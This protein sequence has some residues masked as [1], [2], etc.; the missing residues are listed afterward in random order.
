MN[1]AIVIGCSAYE[2][3]S[4]SQLRFAHRD[5]KRIAMTLL[6]TCG[7]SEETLLILCDDA[8]ESRRPTRTNV[9]RAITDRDRLNAVDGVLF[10]FFSG[11]GF[12]AADE[13]QY[14]L[15]IDCVR[16]ALTDTSLRFDSMLR[17]LGEARADHSV[18]LLDA[19]RN[20]VQ[21]GKSGP[22]APAPVDV[23]A[24]CPPGMVS[25]CSCQP[26]RV[27][28]E[29]ESVQAGV[30]T[31][32]ICEALSDKGRCRTIY[33]LD[34]YLSARVP[35]VARAAGK[36]VQ[37]PYSRVEP[38][39][40]QRLE[41][42]SAQ[43]SNQWRA[44]APIGAERRPRRIQRAIVDAE[45]DPIVAVDLGT[46]YSAV[47]LSNSEGT[48]VIPGADGRLL[49]PSVVH[50]LP[51]LDYL[52]GSAAVEADQYRPEGTV[53]EVKR[54]LGTD[55]NF[56]VADRSIA[57]ELI[58]SLIIRSLR[59][60]AEEALGRPVHRC[61]AS[62]PANFSVAQRNALER[63]F[64]LADFDIMRMIAEPN[65]AAMTL[66]QARP[67]W[68]GP[69]LV[70]DLGGGTF[71]V[72][73]LGYDNS[74][75]SFVCDV[76]AVAGSN[77]VGGTDFDA[78]LMDYAAAE[79]REQ[80]GHDVL[81]DPHLVW[82]LR[83]EAQRAKRELGTQ[84]ATTILVQDVE[85][86]PLG[87]KDISI[88][89]DRDLFRHLTT[90][91]NEEIRSILLRVMDAWQDEVSI[92]PER[93]PLVLLAGQGTKIFTVREQLEALELGAEFITHF[94]ETAVIHGLGRQAGVLSGTVR[95]VLLLDL[96]HR[97]IGIR[98]LPK[99]EG[100]THTRDELHA[101]PSPDT[102]SEEDPVEI[103]SDPK[104]NTAT[105][106]IDNPPIKA[107]PTIRTVLARLAAT[108]REPVAIDLV[109][110]LDG[111]P[112]PIGRVLVPGSPASRDVELTIDVDANTTIVLEVKD[113]GS[114][115]V[116]RYQLNNLH[117]LTAEPILTLRETR[118]NPAI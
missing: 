31:E 78:I 114:G 9:L 70:V 34:R 49:V 59:R 79:V 52:I 25:F 63:A 17:Y 26:G 117:R 54:A 69:C 97:S 74:D 87:L 116:H 33:E 56:E 50:F 101:S 85:A 21:G 29:A 75:G 32:A 81:S 5:A 105:Y 18:L 40:V 94:Q 108:G 62:Y 109:E 118:T 36:P 66:C 82:Q 112:D 72:A 39:D 53:R 51:D 92:Y 65:V 102:A 113:L 6:E 30:F 46:S 86:G 99:K 35:Q 11:H 7:V 64:Q 89:V 88:P 43:K 107:I 71:D 1:G 48:T 77:Q 16:G 44:A 110:F 13:V 91:L 10:F 93:A 55:R 24:L 23:A 83:R 2:D 27:S 76:R 37:Q 15:P 28:Y 4:L 80:T 45:A 67:T 111:R 68:A 95:S 84:P 104:Q 47:S 98:C 115:K 14:L 73:V 90:R 58:A 22:S 38:L 96:L 41:I 12:Q 8:P 3:S 57:P 60:N 20:A 106:E 19:C 100:T 103:G 42:V 61:L